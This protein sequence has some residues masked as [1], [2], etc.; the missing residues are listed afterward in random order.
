MKYNIYAD[1]AATTAMYPEVAEIMHAYFV[2]EFYNPSAL[3][4][5]ASK[6]RRLVKQARET[7]AKQIGAQPEEI[8][9]TSGGSEADNWALKGFASAQ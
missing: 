4:H 8:Y 1:N 2:D 3:Y 6:I 9:F 5:Q 7:I